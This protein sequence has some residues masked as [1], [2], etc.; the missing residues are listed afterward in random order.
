[1]IYV[2]TEGNLVVDGVMATDL[3]AKYSTPLFVM[4]ETQIR[5]NCRLYTSSI[6][7]YYN[8]KGLICYASKAFSCKEI[9]RLIASEGLGIDVVSMGELYTAL[10]VGFPVDKIVFHGNNKSLEELEYAINNNIGFI[11]ADNLD[12]VQTIQNIAIKLNRVI[13]IMLRITPGIDAHTHEFI[14]TGGIDSKFGVLIKYDQAIS[15][16][17]AI[18]DMPNINMVGVHCHIGS[19]IFEI[20]PFEYACD[21]MIKFIKSV[22]TELNIDLKYLNLGGGFGIRYTNED[23][24]P[25][26]DGYMQAVSRKIEECSNNYNIPKPF[27]MLEPGRSIV[28]DAGITL[29]TV[30]NKKVIPNVREYLSVDG[31][32]GDNPR[33]A[34]YGAKYDV[35]IASRA[36]S[37]ATH[38]YTIAGKYCESGDLIAKDI[39]LPECFKN[40]IL[41]VMGTGAYN[42]SMASNYNRFC[43]PA[44][45]M[46][47]NGDTKLIVRRESLQDIVKN[48]I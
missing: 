26:Y 24:P 40:D 47:S 31:G 2:D 42:Y 29:Y 15:A 48:D 45:I 10:S 41:A 4:D 13:D 19:Q 9:Y 7:K 25:N 5:K 43:R 12:E 37:P 21:V 18:K 16:I 36:N 34:L 38:C 3:A 17:C 6:K 44:V 39:Y 1:M 8:G 46:V 32:M 23:N 30:G 28:G 27:I 33:F 35:L 20:E 22:K 14:K 11:I